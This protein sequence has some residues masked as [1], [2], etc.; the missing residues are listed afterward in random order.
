MRQ[1]GRTAEAKR[2]SM[3]G[4]NSPLRTGDMMSQLVLYCDQARNVMFLVFTTVPEER[5]FTCFERAIC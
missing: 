1:R 5:F 2:R 4:G 3:S